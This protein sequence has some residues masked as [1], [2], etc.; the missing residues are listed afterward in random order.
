MEDR[1]EQLNQLFL[2]HMTQGYNVARQ[3][4]GRGPQDLS[5]F[6]EETVVTVEE[7]VVAATTVLF[8]RL[9]NNK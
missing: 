1:D 3:S 4:V 6:L 5:T 7:T 2:D 9:L 8:E